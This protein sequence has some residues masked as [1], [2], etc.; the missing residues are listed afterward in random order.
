MRCRRRMQRR[1]VLLDAGTADRVQRDDDRTVSS[2]RVAA[3]VDGAYRSVV[4]QRYDS[5]VVVPFQKDGW[6]QC[7]NAPASNLFR[8][9][10]EP[11]Y[12]HSAAE[13][14]QAGI[15]GNLCGPNFRSEVDSTMSA[16]FEGNFQQPQVYFI[17]EGD[18]NQSPGSMSFRLKLYK[19]R[20][21]MPYRQLHEWVQLLGTHKAP[22][23]V[24]ETVNFMLTMDPNSEKK[25]TINSNWEDR[26]EV[27]E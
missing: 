9:R 14:T 1:V 6:V 24:E 3:A 26:Q 21:F 10:Q 19:G 12:F 16:A 20:V 13:A 7:D 22:S 2:A 18:E 4:A 5:V 11:Y 15:F 25:Y 23:G 17:G 8:D 27:F